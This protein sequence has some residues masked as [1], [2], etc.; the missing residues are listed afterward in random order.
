MS[1]DFQLELYFKMY[2]DSPMIN[3]NKFRY[4]FI[5]KHGKFQYLPELIFMIER[6]QIKKYGNLIDD[7]VEYQP[8]RKGKKEGIF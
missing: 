6:Y 3:R 1:L 8:G 2:K 5:K 4:K 7:F